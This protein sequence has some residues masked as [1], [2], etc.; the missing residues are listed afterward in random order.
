MKEMKRDGYGS[1]FNTILYDKDCIKKVAK[2]QYGLE[3]MKKEILLYKYLQENCQGFPFPQILMFEENGYTMKYYK[4]YV[5]LYK[6]YTTY[7][8]DKR[9]RILEKIF[10]HLDFLHTVN[11]SVSRDI[12]ER[13]LL[14]E[15]VDKINTRFS[16]IYPSIIT[17][18]NIDT[19]NSVRLLPFKTIMDRV[20]EKI[21][22]FVK[23][24]ESYTYSLLHG[25]CQFNNILYN[26]TIDE[27]VFIDP[28]GYFGLTD[29]YGLAEYDTAKVYF[30]LS[31]YDIFDTAEITLLE[32][33]GNSLTLPTISL[34]GSYLDCPSI[35]KYLLVSIWLGNA[36]C[37]K[38]NPA[39]AAFSYFYACYL[40]T[41]VCNEDM[42]L[43]K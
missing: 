21:L 8:S 23:S 22:E 34:E 3:K 39:K 4:E 14:Y 10:S 20:K 43:M 18:M 42:S 40:G 5:P 38:D 27:M 19:V 37:F 26:E 2:N 11:Y 30:A 17:Y 24:K 33:N 32:I 36:H 15:V 28:R 29:M 16:S 6:V 35:I 12:V 25:D 41:L 9:N 13:D 7:S 1:Q 31:G